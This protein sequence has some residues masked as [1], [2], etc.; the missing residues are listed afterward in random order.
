MPAPC[1]LIICSGFI[2]GMPHRNPDM[3]KVAEKDKLN[4]VLEPENP[5]DPQAIKLVHEASGQ[6]LGYVPRE[7]TLNIHNAIANGFHCSAF[8][9]EL[10]AT[11][12]KECL[13]RV[14][15]EAAPTENSDKERSIS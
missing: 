1:I 4:I 6:F 14:F 10:L 8:V 5:H 12:W 9:V 11:K 7:Q 3:T 13:F 15:V 2:A